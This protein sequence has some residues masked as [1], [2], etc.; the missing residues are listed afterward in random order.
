[1]DTCLTTTNNKTL[2]RRKSPRLLIRN[3]SFVG[4]FKFVN[5]NEYVLTKRVNNETY[6]FKSKFTLPIKY[7]YFQLNDLLECNEAVWIPI[8][9]DLRLKKHL[10]ILDSCLGGSE[11]KVTE[12]MINRIPNK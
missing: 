8:E 2:K 6:G 11:Y 10:E 9:Y 7:S 3:G 12:K 1:M 4:I 5:G